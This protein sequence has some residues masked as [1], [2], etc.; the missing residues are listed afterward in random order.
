MPIDEQAAALTP[1]EQRG[2]LLLKRDD[3]F[4]PFGP[5]GPN[6]GKLR[7]CHYLI[8][9]KMKAGVK[10]VFT[11]CSVHSPQGP[12]VASIASQFG[13]EC[14]LYVGGKDV[15]SASR[16]PMVA[17]ARKFGAKIV[18]CNS[19]RHSVLYHRINKDRESMSGMVVEYGVN[20]ERNYKAL[21]ES[22][23]SQV[24]NIPPKVD[25][26]VMTCGSG[27]SATGVIVGISMFEKEVGELVLVGTA[28]HRLEKIKGRLSSLEKITGKKYRAD[29]IKYVDMFSDPGFSYEREE[30]ASIE[31]VILHPNYEAKVF[32]KYQ[33]LLKSKALP[34]AQTLFWIVGAKPK[35]G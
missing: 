28:P 23:A 7:Q 2:D 4:A 16:H 10:R 17:L 6:G 20:L 13:L 35:E 29:N 25:R 9:G 14:L 19:G 12:I 31:G 30:P 21:V 33:K 1:V 22:T 15:E 11:G 5:G 24:Q 32:A 27:V 34:E 3:L 26:I 18:C 8:A